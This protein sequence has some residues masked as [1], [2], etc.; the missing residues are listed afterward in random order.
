MRRVP[1]RRRRRASDRETTICDLTSTGAQGTA[2]AVFAVAAARQAG[3]GSAISI[4]WPMGVPV[5]G[6]SAP[7]LGLAL[8]LV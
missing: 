8:L 5:L 3:A 2:I 6:G 1:L 4:R 7:S